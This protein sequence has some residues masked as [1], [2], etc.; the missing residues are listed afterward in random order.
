MTIEHHI[1]ISPARGLYTTANHPCLL[2]FTND[3]PPVSSVPNVPS[4]PNVSSPQSPGVNPVDQTTQNVPPLTT[5]QETG[6]RIQLEADSPD[7]NV[8]V[9]DYTPHRGSAPNAAAL[10]LRSDRCAGTPPPL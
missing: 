5:I 10:L 2:H 6:L 9:S 1:L 4:A 7:W 8:D 3:T